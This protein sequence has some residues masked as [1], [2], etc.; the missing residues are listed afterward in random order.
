MSIF[1]V[2]MRHRIQNFCDKKKVK[3]KK[4]YIMEINTTSKKKSQLINKV[5][6]IV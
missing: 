6:T 4:K 2:C 5:I 1:N 3:K